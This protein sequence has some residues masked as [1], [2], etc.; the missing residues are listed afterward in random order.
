MHAICDL[1]KKIIKL[2]AMPKKNIYDALEVG[3]RGWLLPKIRGS[4]HYKNK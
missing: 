4:L 2:L 1:L 3:F